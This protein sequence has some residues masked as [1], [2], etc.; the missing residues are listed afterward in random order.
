[1]Q[2]G[3][4]GRFVDKDRGGSFRQ[5]YPSVAVMNRQSFLPPLRGYGEDAVPS[6]AALAEAQQKRFFVGTMMG[7]ALLAAIVFGLGMRD[8]KVLRGRQLRQVRHTRPR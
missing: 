5:P 7:A 6:C 8:A 2:N 1:M 3:W 4:N